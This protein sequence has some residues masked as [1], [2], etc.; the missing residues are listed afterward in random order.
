MNIIKLELTEQEAK[1]Y[2]E[3]ME[4]IEKTAAFLVG[5]SHEER[6]DWLREHQYS[7]PISF[8]REVGGTVYAVNAHFSNDTAESVEKKVI[9]IL[10]RNIAH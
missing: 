2:D 10:N 8:E 9:R 3:V 1:I 4:Q 6:L 7:L 5:L